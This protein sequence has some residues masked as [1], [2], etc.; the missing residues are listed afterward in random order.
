ME[1][2]M[3]EKIYAEVVRL[4]NKTESVCWIQKNELVRTVINDALLQFQLC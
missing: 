3:E 2:I 4:K 1:K